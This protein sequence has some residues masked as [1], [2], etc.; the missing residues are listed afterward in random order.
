MSEHDRRPTQEVRVQPSSPLPT[1]RQRAE[2]GLPEPRSSDDIES[3]SAQE[4][5][6]VVHELRVHQIE[7]EM[8]NEALRASQLALDELHARFFDLYDVA[9]IGYCTVGERGLIT[10]ANL[11]AASLLGLTRTGLVAQPLT[12]FICSED[13]DTFYLLHKRLVESGAAQS[14]V[15]RMR[16]SDGTQIWTQLAATVAADARGAFE[17]R[18]V[19]SD[20]SELKR[21]EL[22]LSE[23]SARY[24]DLFDA[25]DE[26]YCV[27]EVL[28]DATDVAVDYR[29]VEAN[30]S[31]RK[32]FGLS[33]EAGRSMR[34][35]APFHAAHWV[36]TFGR[37]ALTGQSTRSSDL[38]TDLDQRWFDA[39]AFRIGGTRSRKVA[40][41]FGDVTERKQ[42]EL[43]LREARRNADKANLA[44]SEFLSNMSHEL[45]TPLNAILGFAQL[46]E[47]G[48][49]QPT[50]SQK[51]NV[52]QILKAGWYLLELVNEILDLSVIESGKLTLAE[53]VV[54]LGDV[55]RECAAM[56]EAQARQH[57]VTVEFA[58]LNA[59]RFI[60]GDHTRVK[61]VLINLLSNAIKYNKPNGNVTVTY[62]LPSADR[63]R[64]SVRDTGIGLSPDQLEQLYQPFNRLGQQPGN[65]EGTGIGLVVS[66]R[67]VELMHG[68]IGASSS[69][70][71]GSVFWF[72]LNVSPS[73]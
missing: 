2:A 60:S 12:R 47:A 23:S 72:E 24:R 15:L 39:Y 41:L 11:T 13:E 67:L 26:G 44:K 20:L 34:E 29:F 40:V 49:P 48:T 32:Q 69:V 36:D 68:R 22:A 27:I 66:K 17:A 61:Q 35:F 42:V 18:I 8:Q 19:L 9:P 55:L 25:I 59:P 70:G 21:V 4:R 30:P 38:H 33:A 53:E 56:V 54:A 63:I 10:Q 37:V 73:P 7:L 50:S 64:I 14:C 65:E 45:R 62:E 71:E 31:F 6:S 1:L 43:A 16:R 58:R 5:R 51:A 52:E 57:G 3:M 28:F 46:L